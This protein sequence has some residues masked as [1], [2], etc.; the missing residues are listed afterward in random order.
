MLRRENAIFKSSI[1]LAVVLVFVCKSVL[2]GVF[3][4]WRKSTVN[5]DLSLC[6]F[7]WNNPVP[8]GQFFF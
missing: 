2:L 7:A 6:P 8:T 1:V 5:F 3:A 4:K